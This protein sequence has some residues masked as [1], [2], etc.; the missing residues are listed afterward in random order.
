MDQ[1]KS[2]V[3]QIAGNPSGVAMGVLGSVAVGVFINK[4]LKFFIALSE[5]LEANIVE[6]LSSRSL[7]PRRRP[8]QRLGS[9]R[10]RLAARGWTR[11]R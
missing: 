2:L 8:A 4:I 5:D 7:S 9:R 3:E 1:L 6:S 11:R 10:P